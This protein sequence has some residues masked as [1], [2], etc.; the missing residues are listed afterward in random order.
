LSGDEY[1]LV[2]SH[3]PLEIREFCFFQMILIAIFANARAA[4]TGW[5]FRRHFKKLPRRSLRQ[6][7]IF[8]WL[9][10]ANGFETN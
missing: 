9:E 1:F 8:S 7:L 6:K 2:C 5:R 10:T 3:I 4:K